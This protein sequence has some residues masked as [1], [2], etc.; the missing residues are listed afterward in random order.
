MSAKFGNFMSRIGK[1]PVIIPSGVTAEVANQICKVKG[2]KG[3]LTLSV[4]PKVA[5]AIADNSIVVSVKNESVKAERALW[6]LF[7]SLIHNMVTGVHTGFSK[8]LDIVGVGYRAATKGKVLSMNLGYSHPVDYEVP[9]GVTA[10]VENNTHIV[11]SGAD[12]MLVGMVAAKIRSF[13]K[14]EPYQGKGIK[15]VNEHIVRKQGKAAG[16]K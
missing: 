8:E 3:E 14:P 4:H 5:V 15:Y 16:A 2:P 11:V 1:K 6:G 10:Q 7:R 12:K 13:K 9:P